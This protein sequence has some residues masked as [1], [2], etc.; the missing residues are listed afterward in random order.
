MLIEIC[1]EYFNSDDIRHMYAEDEKT[2]VVELMNGDEYRL[3]YSEH[4]MCMRIEA[5]LKTI[6]H[7][8]N[9]TSGRV[10]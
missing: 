8:I 7:G 4:D 3:L 1:E 10:R 2:V 6:V 5:Y 9:M